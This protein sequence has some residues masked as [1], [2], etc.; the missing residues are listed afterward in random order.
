MKPANRFFNSLYSPIYQGWNGQYLHRKFKCK[1]C[2][3]IV[4]YMGVWKYVHWCTYNVNTLDT[5]C[6]GKY[7]G[8][9]CI[10]LYLPFFHPKF[11]IATAA[12]SSY[13]Y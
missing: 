1:T 2:I 8:H 3:L 9:T 13:K 7:I 11:I 4:W 12:K 10:V 5:A 6:G